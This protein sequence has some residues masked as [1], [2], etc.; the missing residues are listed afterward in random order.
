M[1]MNY[2]HHFQGVKLQYFIQ[3]ILECKLREKYEST[4]E[5]DLI[6]LEKWDFQLKACTEKTLKLYQIQK[7]FEKYQTSFEKYQKSVEKYQKSFEKYK[8]TPRWKFTCPNHVDWIGFGADQN[9]SFHI[10]QRG[11]INSFQGNSIT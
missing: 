7:S 3:F 11:L 10:M 2:T 4:Q 9:V 5:S 1:N 6:C 8:K